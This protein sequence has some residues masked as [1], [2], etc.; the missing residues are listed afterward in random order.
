[1]VEGLKDRGMD[2]GRDAEK[3][4]KEDQE[5]LERLLLES[6]Q[7]VDNQDREKSEYEIEEDETKARPGMETGQPDAVKSPE[8]M[9]KLSEIEDG[10]SDASKYITD[11]ELEVNKGLK[12]VSTITTESEHKMS[13]A[14]EDSEDDELYFKNLEK[15][16]EIW[17]KKAAAETAAAKLIPSQNPK[18]EEPNFWDSRK[19]WLKKEKESEGD[20]EKGKT[21]KDGSGPAPQTNP[22][23]KKKDW[24]KLSDNIGVVVPYASTGNRSRGKTKNLKGIEK[25][26][27]EIVYSVKSAPASVGNLSR[28]PKGRGDESDPA[29]KKVITE[30]QGKSV[31]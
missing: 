28:N 10:E 22:W 25:A 18:A 24:S 23:A 13:W 30:L 11:Q 19:P 20:D 2:R 3:S 4:R 12:N 26:G 21:G 27:R 1:M 17:K 9:Q 6:M 5:A 7:Q 14:D 8:D 31:L 15:E 16:M 29:N